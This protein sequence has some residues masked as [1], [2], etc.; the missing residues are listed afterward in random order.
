MKVMSEFREF[1]KQLSPHLFWD[2]D[3]ASLDTQAHAGFVICRVMERGNSSDARHVWAFYGEDR[4]REALTSAPA[5]SP[6]TIHF[7]ANQF[8]ISCDAFRAYRRGH[9]WAV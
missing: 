2:V 4:I 5:L 3:P 8:Q 7:F 6:K 1:I 9:N